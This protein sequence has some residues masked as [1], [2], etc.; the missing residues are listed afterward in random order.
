VET[1]AIAL[2][3]D[4]DLLTE[5][6]LARAIDLEVSTLREWRHRR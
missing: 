4:L 6:E 5:D 1:N 3:D 2:R